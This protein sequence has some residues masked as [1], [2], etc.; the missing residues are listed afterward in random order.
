[1]RPEFVFAVLTGSAVLMLLAALAFRFK[2]RELQHREH[3]VAMEKGVALPSYPPVA[4]P[5]TPRVYLLRGLTWLFTGIALAIFLF[6][7]SLTAVHERTAA[8]RVL[9]ANNAKTRGATDEQI[10]EIMNDRTESGGFPLSASLIGLIPAGV[11]LAY[12]V[13][14][15]VERRSGAD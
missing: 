2:Q 3:L 11:G 10:R 7:Y 9:D 14:Y 12:L 13:T 6:G 5:W 1:M 15:R 8:N 4:P